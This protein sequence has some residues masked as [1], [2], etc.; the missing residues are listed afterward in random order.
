M[1]SLQYRVAIMCQDAEKRMKSLLR[2]YKDDPDRKIGI[3]AQA[4]AAR[5]YIYIHRPAMSTSSTER[6]VTESYSNLMPQKTELFKI[7]E[8]LPTTITIDEDGFQNT[9]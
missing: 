8:V 4:F 1:A 3:V 5:K 9:V 2:R 7:I 6:L